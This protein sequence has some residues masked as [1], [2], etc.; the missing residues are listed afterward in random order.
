MLP[1]DVVRPA[2][3]VV[4]VQRLKQDERVG[5][6]STPCEPVHQSLHQPLVLRIVHLRPVEPTASPVH[7]S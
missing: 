1:E 7:T 5:G 6:V 4:R 2:V 3:P